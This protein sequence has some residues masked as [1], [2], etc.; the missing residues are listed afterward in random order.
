MEYGWDG[1][2][3]HQE[4]RQSCLLNDVLFCVLCLCVCVYVRLY[5]RR[6]RVKTG[7]VWVGDR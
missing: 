4:R 7:F 2:Y 3:G 6:G 1:T 5:E